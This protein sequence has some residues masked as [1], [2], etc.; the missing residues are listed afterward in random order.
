MARTLVIF[1]WDNTLSPSSRGIVDANRLKSNIKRCMK[2]LDSKQNVDVVI[3]TN[4][5]SKG[6]YNVFP[7]INVPVYSAREGFSEKCSYSD[8]KP[9]MFNKVIKEMGPDQIIGI[10]DSEG[11]AHCARRMGKKYG[12]PTKCIQFIPYPTQKQIEV[13]LHYIMSV[14]ERIIDMKRLEDMVLTPKA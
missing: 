10:G 14:F 4:S 5:H 1:D 2:F 6:V 7:S 3:V 8:W 9:Q 12:L 11:D 13:Q